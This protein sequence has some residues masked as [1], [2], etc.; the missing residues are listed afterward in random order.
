MRRKE[1][2]KRDKRKHR[3]VNNSND[4]ADG[5]G[6][7]NERGIKEVKTGAGELE[8]GKED[9]ERRREEYRGGRYEER[10]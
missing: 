7:R 10:W 5:D 9:G 6:R 8:N 3:E 1:A 4:E 2:L